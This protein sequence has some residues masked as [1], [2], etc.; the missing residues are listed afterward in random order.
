MLNFPNGFF[1]C[2]TRNILFYLIIYF[3][4][5]FYRHENSPLNISPSLDPFLWA[6]EMAVSEKIVDYLSINFSETLGLFPTLVQLSFSILY[7]LSPAAN[8]KPFTQSYII[9]ADWEGEK[10]SHSLFCTIMQIWKASFGPDL[11]LFQTCKTKR[12]KL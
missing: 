1:L 8:L 12:A 9:P 7:I 10:S 3:L 4:Q 6:K 5:C 2:M 11:G